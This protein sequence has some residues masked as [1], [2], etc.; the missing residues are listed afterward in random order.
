MVLRLAAK[1][2]L[3]YNVWPYLKHQ[4]HIR[5]NRRNVF[6]LQVSCKFLKPTFDVALPLIFIAQ[7]D[8]EMLDHKQCKTK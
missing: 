5:C 3:I 2:L 6:F 8:Q 4:L 1:A 7:L